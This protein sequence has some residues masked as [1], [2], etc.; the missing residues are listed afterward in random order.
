MKVVSMTQ[1]LDTDGSGD[2][3]FALT[4]LKRI[5]RVLEVRVDKRGACGNAHTVSGRTVTVRV[6]QSGNGAGDPFVA[7]ATTTD[8][9]TDVTV[10]AEGY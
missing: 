1:T 7:E 8:P 2:Q 5:H 3:V 6:Y 9:T 10:V 4:G